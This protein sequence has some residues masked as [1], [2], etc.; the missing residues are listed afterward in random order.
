[1]THDYF[2]RIR[3]FFT[4]KATF[5]P[6]S[7]HIYENYAKLTLRMVLIHCQRKTDLAL[8]SLISRGAF[9]SIYHY[10]KP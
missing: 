7:H 1:M 4:S 3:F 2:R 10:S 9:S 5:L 6:F 8:R